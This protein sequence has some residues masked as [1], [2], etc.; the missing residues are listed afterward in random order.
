LFIRGDLAVSESSQRAGAAEYAVLRSQLS[1]VSE[2]L[3]QTQLHLSEE[4]GRVAA[5]REQL[6]TLEGDSSSDAVRYRAQIAELSKALQVR[7]KWEWIRVEEG[8]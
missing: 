6:S 2:Q 7:Q 5:L 3:E 4:Q 1:Q 8:I